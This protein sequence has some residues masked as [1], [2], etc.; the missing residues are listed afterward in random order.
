MSDREPYHLQHR[1][2]ASSTETNPNQDPAIPRALL[3]KDISFHQVYDVFMDRTVSPARASD[4]PYPTAF[5][6]V[7]WSPLGL[8]ANQKSFVFSIDF[9]P[10]GNPPDCARVFTTLSYGQ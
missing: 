6:Q 3:N 10:T 9:F 2:I 5:R 7:S 1:L 4:E 8:L